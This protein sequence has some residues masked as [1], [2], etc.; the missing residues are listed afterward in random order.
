MTWLQSLGDSEAVSLIGRIVIHSIWQGV[1]IGWLAAL[2]LGLM[3]RRSASARYALAGG[4][5]AAI[6]LAP[7]ATVVVAD[8]AIHQQLIGAL[9]ILPLRSDQVGWLA[10]LSPQFATNAAAI[11]FVGASC[12]LIR[13]LRQWIGVRTMLRCG[14]RSSDPLQIEADLLRDRLGIARP[15]TV[16]VSAFATTPLILGWLRPVILLPISATT[17]LTPIQLRMIMAHELA[18][19]ARADYAIN[20]IQVAVEA[21]MF[22]HPAVW[23]LSHRIRVEREFCCDD[24]AVA[25]GEDALQYA[26]ALATLEDLRA[27]PDRLSVAASGGSLLCRI[28]RL[29]GG[30]VSAPTRPSHPLA[31]VLL[32]LVLLISVTGSAFAMANLGDA[33]RA[34]TESVGVRIPSG[35][36][37]G[38]A[39]D[40]ATPDFDPTLAPSAEDGE[41]F[42]RR[43]GP[44]SGSANQIGEYR[45]PRRRRA[46]GS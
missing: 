44:D 12:F 27:A 46:P 9:R 16:L 20:L 11:W 29:V 22:Y 19:V 43:P 24:L 2:V 38:D 8:G 15:V 3:R 39:F 35:P 32:A 13:L 18:H 31:A 17:G 33:G 30:S 40:F 5:L 36:A 10:G 23:W 37:N 45:L 25:T 41:F 34:A 1:L 14:G 7:I 4:A 26:R 42:L 28:Q 6:V 21:L